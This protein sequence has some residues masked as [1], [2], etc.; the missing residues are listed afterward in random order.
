MK[1]IGMIIVLIVAVTC[2]VGRTD[3]NVNVVEFP[4]CVDPADQYL[5]EISG[6]NLAWIDGR[7]VNLNVYIKSLSTG[8]ETPI[9]SSQ[10]HY[11]SEIDIE[12]D[13]VMWPDDRNH[14]AYGDVYGYTI[15]TNT[16]FPVTTGGIGAPFVD[17][18]GTLVVYTTGDIY[19][20]DLSTGTT[21]PICTV[22]G[23]QNDPATNG[24]IIVW[25]DRRA[26]NND[27]YGYDM[28]TQTEFPICVDS[29]SQE[30]PAISGDI[31]VWKDDRNW[32]PDIYGYDLNTHT[33]FAISTIGGS[34][35]PS[36]N[37]NIVVWESHISGQYDRSPN[38][39]IYGYDL[40]THTEF[41]ICTDEG[42]QGRPAIY[43][44]T[45]VW[46]DDRNGNIDIYGA[47]IPEPCT[48]SLFI[49]GG[50]AL[51]RTRKV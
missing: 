48:I 42:Y 24:E 19:A 32:P 35:N 20:H 49:L 38:W 12:G 30:M 46:E 26:G 40:T 9:H 36:I 7:N 1:N 28:N 45:V 25:T 44:N 23:G 14:I 5:P 50:L 37:G 10:V 22:P 17:V 16:E 43:D 8:T 2:F 4:I 41:P 47:T 21:F 51:A 31:V 6:D 33:E 34:G 18:S 13:V 29:A 11:D 3:A 39:D 15:S 27:I